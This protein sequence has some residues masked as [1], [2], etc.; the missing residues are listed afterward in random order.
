MHA[1]V[2][3]YLAPKVV[4]ELLFLGALWRAVREELG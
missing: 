4:L 2:N 3:G 1:G